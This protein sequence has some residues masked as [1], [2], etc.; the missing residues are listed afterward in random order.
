MHVIN[1]KNGLDL[2]FVDRITTL[3]LHRTD[4]LAG[5]HVRRRGFCLGSIWRWLAVMVGR[6]VFATL[7]IRHVIFTTRSH[8]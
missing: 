8:N 3:D 7:G 5:A 4:H 1:A 2:G 6:F